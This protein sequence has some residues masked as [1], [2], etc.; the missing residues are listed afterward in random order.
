MHK[1]FNPDVDIL[2][3][4]TN[5]LSSEKSPKQIS[6]DILNLAKSMKLNN[7]TVVVSNIVPCDDAYKKRPMKPV[8]N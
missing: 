6:L 4:G 3:V 8:Q 5:D 2:Y 1:D 7:N